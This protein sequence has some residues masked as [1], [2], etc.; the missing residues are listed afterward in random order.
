M[1]MSID[2]SKKVLKEKYEL[3]D[4]DKNGTLDYS[5]FCTFMDLLRK[6]PELEVLWVNAVNGKWTQNV[7]R[8]NMGKSSVSADDLKLCTMPINIFAEFWS[9][10]QGETVSEEDVIHKIHHALDIESGDF[11]DVTY[12]V[13]MKIVDH[14]NNI[15][16]PVRQTLYQDMTQPLSH[17]FI[18]SSHNTYLEGDQIAGNSSVSRYIDDLLKGFR[19]VEIDIWDGD[20]GEPIV[21]HGHTFTSSI[22]FH[23]VLVAIK[24]YAFRLSP[25]PVIISLDN[26][27]SL[28]QQKRMAEVLVAQLGNSLYAPP[29]ASP[30]DESHFES[31]PSPEALKYKILLKAKKEIHLPGV[32]EEEPE[33]TG[34]SG[35]PKVSSR[36]RSN[37]FN[38]V[39]ANS[40][41]DGRI[42]TPRSR[43]NSLNPDASLSPS[44]TPKTALQS[45]TSPRSPRKSGGSKPTIHPDLAAIVFLGGAAFPKEHPPAAA[46]MSASPDCVISA[47]E[48]TCLKWLKTDAQVNQWIRWNESHFSRIYP[49]GVRYDS[50]NYNPC[51]AWAAGAQLVA[52][53]YQTPG[54][55][56]QVNDG[57]FLENGQCGYVLKPAYM[58]RD[59]AKPMDGVLL[60]IHILSGQQIPK[61]NGAK[62]GEVIDPYVLVSVHGL[63][64]DEVVHRT[65][66]V[67]NNGFNPVWDEVINLKIL[68]P[69]VAIVHF[70]V[71]NE[72]GAAS[73]IAYSAVPVPC[74]RS[75]LR[76][77][78][79][80]DEK[81]NRHGD[82]QFAHLCVRIGYRSLTGKKLSLVQHNPPPP[83]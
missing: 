73:F 40:N 74:L 71:H 54:I 7:A 68:H 52:L 27:C 12:Y 47:N 11:T 46:Q 14:N 56:M 69:E 6:R 41:S 13:W 48:S 2:V 25:Y 34:N 33:V 26:N 58:I 32:A 30:T 10:V 45:D 4:A 83:P 9:V 43:R 53:N 21:T 5:D 19:C 75:G 57:K 3:S 18:S 76:V 50:S 72:D 67:T 78:T 17:Y 16:D 38:P 59:S 61:P 42:G 81:G 64:C 36:P 20:G 79:L 65:H 55:P 70:A 23:D 8:L 62:I 29:A 60:D 63:A 66:T 51:G 28:D 77:V 49:D 39:S 35:D 15:Y 44:A 1:S 22:L 37:S 80:C 31:L 82:F 24:R